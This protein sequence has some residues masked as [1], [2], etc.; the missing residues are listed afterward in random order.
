[1]DHSTK[2]VVKDQVAA[3][4]PTA[5]RTTLILTAWLATLLLSRLPQIILSELGVITPSDWSLWW[6][7]IIGALLFAL[8]YIWAAVRPLRGYFLI[9][10]M[11]YAFTILLSLLAQSSIWKSWFGSDKPWLASFFGDRLGVV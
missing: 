1:M 5:T 4:T 3:S 2:S 6:W 9:M 11:I 7:I 10:T 8:T